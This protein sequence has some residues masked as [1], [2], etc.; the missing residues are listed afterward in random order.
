M[1]LGPHVAVAGMVTKKKKKKKEK[2]KK[3]ARKQTK[4]RSSEIICSQH[5]NFHTTSHFLSKPIFWR[6]FNLSH[7][8]GKILQWVTKMYLPSFFNIYS[9]CVLTRGTCNRFSARVSEREPTSRAGEEGQERGE[10]NLSIDQNCESL[11][12]ESKGF[13]HWKIS[14]LF[15]CLMKIHDI[16]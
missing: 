16:Y 7:Y 10:S 13:P 8:I 5:K 14:L 15:L 2:K 4:S 6:P 9:S 11:I 12:C 1:Q 3:N